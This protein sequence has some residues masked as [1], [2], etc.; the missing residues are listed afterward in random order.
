[1][2]DQ[3]R[4]DSNT[5]GGNVCTS[6][7]LEDAIMALLPASIANW[8]RY[9]APCNF[10]VRDIYQ[11]HLQGASEERILE[12]MKGE[13]RVQT[14]RTYGDLHPQLPYA[15]HEFDMGRNPYANDDAQMLAAR[16]A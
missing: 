10:D 14:M 13:A 15:K 11:A 1:M 6:L 12:S 9:D 3:I 5:P 2:A 7:L 8:L 16:A 4:I